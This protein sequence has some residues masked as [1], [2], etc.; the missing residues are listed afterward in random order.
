MPVEEKIDIDIFK[1]VFRAIAESDNLEIMANHLTQLLVAALEIKGC[2]LFALNQ[3]YE[4]LEVLASFGLSMKYLNKGPLL[5]VKSI[6]ATLRGKPIV[7]RDVNK[8]DQLQY[9]DD[10]KKEGIGAIV[11]VPILFYNKVIGALRLY[12]NEAWEISDKDIDSLLVL[13]ENIGLAMTYTRLLNAFKT[14]KYTVQEV[15]PVGVETAEE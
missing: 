1:V 11:S 8:T 3:E 4:E 13:A 9:P 5:T 6:G 2:T 10:A 15:Q 12:H 14:I 7:I